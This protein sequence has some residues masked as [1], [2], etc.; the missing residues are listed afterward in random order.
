MRFSNWLF[1]KV[2]RTDSIALPRLGELVFHYLT[3]ELGQNQQLC[4]EALWHDYQRG[5]RKDKPE[6]LRP[7][8]PETAEEQRPR[9]LQPKRQARHFV[10][11]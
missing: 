10:A 5:G 3:D 9:S 4:A 2:G 8:I 6:Y 11:S 7:Y 1:T